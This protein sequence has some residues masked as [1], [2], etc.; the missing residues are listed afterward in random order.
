MIATRSDITAISQAIVSL[1]PLPDRLIVLNELRNGD[2]AAMRKALVAAIAEEHRQRGQLAVHVPPW[3]TDLHLTRA[4]KEAAL[5]AA[6]DARGSRYLS[7]CMP[8]YWAVITEA[9]QKAEVALSRRQS[10]RGA[11]IAARRETERRRADFR[12]KHPSLSEMSS[13]LLALDLVK[14]LVICC[15]AVVNMGVVGAHFGIGVGVPWERIPLGA[16][17]QTLGITGAVLV[18]SVMLSQYLV[19]QAMKEDSRLRRAGVP[20][21]ILVFVGLGFVFALMRY[22]G[23]S[24]LVGTT[25]GV[26]QVGT[27]GIV[28]LAVV[29][30][31]A[32]AMVAAG[33]GYVSQLR[34]SARRTIAAEE[35][36]FALDLKAA[37]EDLAEHDATAAEDTH[38][39]RLP[40]VAAAHFEQSVI[41]AGAFLTD[42][43]GERDDR[44]MRAE[45]AFKQ[46][47]SVSI[48]D[49][50]QVDAM[51]RTL[52]DA[53][54][55]VGA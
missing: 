23:V 30:G 44:I 18:V 17:L 40:A 11:I 7:A 13:A 9:A 41:S 33:L 1:K 26:A 54:E 24:D 27:L 16:R 4:W 49:R 52:V 14:Y 15:E 50:E 43:E 19:H 42:L 47:V 53:G 22:A 55:K 3:V 25:V 46:G 29:I 45:A 32:A 34:R 6:R 51:L 36:R 28:A 37:D 12:G 48:A 21:A 8:E 38:N 10:A 39:E 2:I 35:D 31:F 20:L 5:C